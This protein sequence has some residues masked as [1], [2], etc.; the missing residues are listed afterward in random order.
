MLSPRP[1]GPTSS[2]SQVNPLLLK[3]SPD[4]V[5]DFYVLEAGVA[6]I[7]ITGKGSIMKAT[8]GIAFGE[9]ALLHNAPRAATVVADDNVTAWAL[10]MI[11]FKMILMGK[12]QTDNADYLAF[13]KAVPLLKSLDATSLQTMASA[14]KEV[15][16]A[17]YPHAPLTSHSH[18]TSH[19]THPSSLCSS[20]CWSN[21]YRMQ[22]CLSQ[23]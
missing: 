5:Q 12:S 14:L 6:D 7:S 2:H 8:K 3:T 17:P 4:T 15:N 16:S 22:I 23:Q 20:H 19:R 13:L 9:L 11:S 1:R 10:D 21:S 18:C